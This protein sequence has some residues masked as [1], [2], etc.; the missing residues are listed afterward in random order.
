MSNKF[1]EIFSGD[2]LGKLRAH[3]ETSRF[4]AQPDFVKAILDI[5]QNPNSLQKYAGDQRIMTA[6][7]VLLGIPLTTGNIS[8]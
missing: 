3:P 2:V 1:A 6:L 7:G 4:V 8:I 5:Q